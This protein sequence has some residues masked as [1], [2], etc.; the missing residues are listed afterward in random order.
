M[1]GLLG[2][3]GGHASPKI[4]AVVYILATTFLAL[5]LRFPGC[6]KEKI[7]FRVLSSKRGDWG[8]EVAYW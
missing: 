2:S 8:S 4:L 3:G 6:L 5:L 1:T 7:V